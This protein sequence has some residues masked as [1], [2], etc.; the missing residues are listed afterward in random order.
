MPL[1]ATIH[2]DTGELLH[3]PRSNE[4]QL[5]LRLI[6]VFSAA[7]KELLYEKDTIDE[8][9]LENWKDYTPLPLEPTPVFFQDC[10]DLNPPKPELYLELYLNLLDMGKSAIEKRSDDGFREIFTDCSWLY[11][12][13]LGL[14]EDGEWDHLLESKSDNQPTA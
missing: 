13:I 7:A 1:F 6:E 9:V 5:A 10:Q 4:R 11:R 2:K 3:I 14:I 8:E 12:V